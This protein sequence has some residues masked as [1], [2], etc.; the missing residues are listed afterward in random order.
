MYTDEQYIKCVH[1]SD[2]AVFAALV[3]EYIDPLV[4]FALGI[5]GSDDI[6]HDVVQDVFTSIWAKRESWKPR[7]SVAAYLFVSVRNRS[8]D[9]L[10]ID[11]NRERLEARLVYENDKSVSES[12]TDTT[13]IGELT[14]G[15]NLLSD[16]QRQAVHLRYYQGLTVQEVAEVLNIDVRATRRLLAR[17][18][19]V[20]QS[21]LASFR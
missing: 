16:R 5:T 7:S 10:R 14:A 1:T 19:T 11:K 21:Y 17:S 12:D 8:I 6:A 2:K 18:I 13:L 9:Q 20:L 3:R 15:L 4:R